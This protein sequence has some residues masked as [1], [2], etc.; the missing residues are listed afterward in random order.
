[1]PQEEGAVRA[2]HC[3]AGR[4]IGGHG[5]RKHI[6]LTQAP[7]SH[8]CASQRMTCLSQPPDAS[9]LE[10][11]LKL[12]PH[13]AGDLQTPAQRWGR[14]HSLQRSLSKSALLPLSTCR[15]LNLVT[16]HRRTVWSQE[17]LA[18]RWPSGEKRQDLTGPE[19]AR[20]TGIV[21]P[22]QLTFVIWF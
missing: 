13:S 4:S 5:C 22:S 6:T 8:T 20:N 14:G 18:T 9:C 2:R 21:L 15:H 7:S 16:S 11:G 1:M 17:E 3:R 10:S 12:S 19:E